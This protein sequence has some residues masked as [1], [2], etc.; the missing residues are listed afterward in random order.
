MSSKNFLQKMLQSLTG[1]SGW[2]R[3]DHNVD[4]NI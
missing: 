1:G 2:L 4:V 3:N